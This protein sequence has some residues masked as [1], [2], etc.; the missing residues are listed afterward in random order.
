MSRTLFHALQCKSR[1][2]TSEF[3]RAKRPF[4]FVGITSHV[5]IRDKMD[6][7]KGKKSLHAKNLLI[8]GTHSKFIVI[9]P[10]SVP[11]RQYLDTLHHT[12]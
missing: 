1:F 2:F 9:Q 3:S 8:Y 12:V 4:S 5:S 10:C 7:D 11:L 6:A